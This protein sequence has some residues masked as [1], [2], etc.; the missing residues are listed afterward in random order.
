MNTDM[1][2]IL[3]AAMEVHAHLGPGYTEPVYQEALALEFALRRIAHQREVHVLVIYKGTL[4]SSFYR[5][6]FVCEQRLVIELKAVTALAAK[7]TTQV[8]NYLRATGKEHGLLLNFGQ[9]RL[10]FQRIERSTSNNTS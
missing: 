1:R 10:Q 9:Q 6:D 4:L 5:A 8:M 2:A 3:G 7:D